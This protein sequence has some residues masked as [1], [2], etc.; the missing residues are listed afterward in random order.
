MKVLRFTFLLFLALT[1]EMA[2]GQVVEPVMAALSVIPATQILASGGVLAL[3]LAIASRILRSMG[4]GPQAD[5]LEHQL[6]AT[7]TSTVAPINNAENKEDA[8]GISAIIPPGILPMFGYTVKKE[9]TSEPPPPVQGGSYPAVLLPPNYEDYAPY[10][11]PAPLPSNTESK[12]QPFVNE[13]EPIPSHSMLPPI[14]VDPSPQHILNGSESRTVSNS[15][16]TALRNE[17]I[18][19][20][21]E[22]IFPQ[23]FNDTH[24]EDNKLSESRNE[25]NSILRMLRPGYGDAFGMPIVKASNRTQEI[26]FNP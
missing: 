13:T 14:L 26:D 1:G 16:S 6:E 19:Y 12:Y 5:K 21:P 17:T 3:K 15:T 20:L 2:S 11:Q 25:S 10:K 24:F 8:G 23:R 4:Y 22:L 18:N 9:D 7:T